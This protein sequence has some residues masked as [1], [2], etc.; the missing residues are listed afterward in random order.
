VRQGRQLGRQLG[1]A[2]AN[3]EVGEE[4]LLENGVYL[5]EGNGIRGVAN[6]GTRP[7]VDQ[8]PQRSLEV[9]LFS[10]EI[11]MAY[12]WDLEV[13]FLRKIREEKKFAGVEELKVQIAKD[14]AEAQK[15]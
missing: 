12:G 7:T 8:S 4:Q 9:H 3:V 1:F 14:V 5:V 2:T 6:I 15:G 10:D 11:P 13:S